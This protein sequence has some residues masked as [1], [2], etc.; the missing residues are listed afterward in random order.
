M[1][2]GI[3]GLGT[4]GSALKDVCEL[5]GHS[6]RTYDIEVESGGFGDILKTDACLICVPTP[7]CAEEKTLDI[8]AVEETL[9]RLSEDGY[10]G[11]KVVKSTMPIGSTRQ[12]DEEYG[13]VYNP[14][15]MRSDSA[16]EDIVNPEFVVAA[17]ADSRVLLDVYNWV[18]SDKFHFV[19]FGTAEGVKL[20][21]NALGGVKVSFA[22][23]VGKI[24]PNG[25]TVMDIVSKSKKFAEYYLDPSKGPY[26]GECFPKDLSEMAQYSDIIRVAHEVN[27]GFLRDGQ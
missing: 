23:E 6:V 8:T 16:I 4:V 21:S 2:I 1:K 5:F 20:V 19:Q 7:F 15:F 14:E 25:K 22:L 17:G 12:L 18:N 26:E 10:E 11:V 24:F 9:S 3:V 13:I 27:E